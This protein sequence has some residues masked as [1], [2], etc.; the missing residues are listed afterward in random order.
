MAPRDGAQD[1]VASL[2]HEVSSEAELV[3]LTQIL[4]Q[5][6]YELRLEIPGQL[7]KPL[8]V[9]K[10]LVERAALGTRRSLASLRMILETELRAL[11]SQRNQSD[12]RLSLATPILAP[13]SAVPGTP[14][15]PGLI[16]GIIDQIDV[17]R[18]V[19]LIGST[20]LVISED[21]RL[22]RIAEGMSVIARFLAGER[23]WTL[24]VGGEAGRE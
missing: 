15:V 12:S 4:D 16:R 17:E 3:E 11:R 13:A 22:D 21:T 23:R 2:L 9:P 14:P 6:S 5:D 20:E 24:T 10:L 1:F 19:I 8:R 7:G 18:R